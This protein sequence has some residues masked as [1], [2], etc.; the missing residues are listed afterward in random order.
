[1]KTDGVIL[2]F[3]IFVV[4][5]LDIF[6]T[7]KQITVNIPD[8]KYNFFIELINSL[9]F[10]TYQENPADYDPE[11]VGKI[12]QAEKEIQQGKYTEVKPENIS[13]FIENL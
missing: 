4:L 7:M 13:S 6:R 3:R 12:Q 10:K 5:I 8:N 1:M 9:G 11:F 2:V